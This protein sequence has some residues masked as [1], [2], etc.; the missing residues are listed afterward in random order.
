MKQSEALQMIRARLGAALDIQEQRTF[1]IAI[2]T[3]QRLEQGE[4]FSVKPVVSQ[5]DGSGRIDVCWMGMLA[6]I[7]PA[8]AKDIALGLLGA[9]A[10]AEDDS[11]LMGF[12]VQA[13]NM[14]PTDA[15]NAIALIRQAR[16]ERRLREPIKGE[17]QEPPS[18]I[19]FPGGSGK[20]S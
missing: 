18:L 2:Q 20:P 14:G 12:F 4:G 6:Q 7:T 5:R 8:Q 19:Q 3:A 15:G 13:L 10:E 1:G 16:D 11:I 17:A 9:S